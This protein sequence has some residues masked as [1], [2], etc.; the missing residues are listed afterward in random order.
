[1]AHTPAFRELIRWLQQARRRNL[2]E[3]GENPPLLKGRVRWT[4][5]RFVKSVAVAGAAGV[6][7]F[8]WP[9]ITWTRERSEPRIAIIGAGI[10]GLNAAY[11]IKKAG[12][13]ASVY[14]A[15]RRIGGRVLSLTGAI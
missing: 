9:S 10:A 5:R 13:H 15:R 12:Y 8:A 4:R 3:D 7:P 2:A 6:A 1:M 11:W 14:E